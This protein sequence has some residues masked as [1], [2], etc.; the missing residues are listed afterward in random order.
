MQ[1]FGVKDQFTVRIDTLTQATTKAQRHVQAL[2]GFLAPLYLTLVYAAVLGGIGIYSFVGGGNLAVVGAVL[3]L[4]L[5]SLA[6]GQQLATSV[7]ALAANAPFLERIDQERAGYEQQPAVSGLLSP[8]RATPIEFAEVDFRYNGPRH[9]LSNV[10]FIITAGEVIGVIG[11]SGAGKSTLAQLVL[12]LREPESGS[13]FVAG[14]R[15]RDVDRSW[16]TR[17]AVF[18][19]QEPRL[20]TGTVAEN[21]RFFR[22][23]ID[24][25]AIRRAA[26]RANILADIEALPDGFDAHLGERGSQLSGGQRQRLSI[27]R[28]LAG[29]PEIL[30][31]DE[32]TSALDGKSEALIRQTLAELKGDVTVV[33]IA[34]RMSTLD[35]CDRIM[36]IEHGRV[37]GLA[38]PAEL[39]QTN[40]FYREALAIARSE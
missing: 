22:E 33:L 20:F 36:V 10:S 29:D 15:L 13:V 35:I 11:P 32:P 12:G 38:A 14:V 6:Y 30:I 17:R 28:A 7:G 18:V 19:A 34:H 24:D 8:E 39:R 1:V 9:T 2:Q 25:H 40:D 16:W 4:M 23:G 3:L 27:A 21:I 26:Q 37:T 31:L 5:R